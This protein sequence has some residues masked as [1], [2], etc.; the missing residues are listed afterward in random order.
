MASATVQKITTA[1]TTGASLDYEVFGKVQG[2]FFRKHTKTTADT[3][4]VSGWVRNQK[5][6]FASCICHSLSTCRFKTQSRA[7]LRDKLLAQWT[8]S[9]Q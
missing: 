1:S 8:Q 3:L 6:P 4:G 5:C 9:W 2:V 7:L